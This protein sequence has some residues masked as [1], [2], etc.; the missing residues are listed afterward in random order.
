MK[1]FEGFDVQLFISKNKLLD[2]AFH[3]PPN[4]HIAKSSHKLNDRIVFKWWQ[5]QSLLLMSC[6]SA[7]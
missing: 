5:Y 4:I 1:G 3:S 6:R 2:L 7:S